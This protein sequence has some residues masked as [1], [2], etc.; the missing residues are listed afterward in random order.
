MLL[1]LKRAAMDVPESTQTI[2][3]Q[4]ERQGIP[5]SALRIFGPEVCQQATQNDAQVF[6]KIRDL[7]IP[8]ALELVGEV[9]IDPSRIK[10]NLIWPEGLEESNNE[11]KRKNHRGFDMW[12]AAQ[13]PKD[14]SQNQ[15]EKPPPLE[16]PPS[17]LDRT[18]QWFV[19]EEG[20]PIVEYTT[21]F[22]IEGPPM[23][24][25]NLGTGFRDGQMF[26]LPIR[27]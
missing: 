4:I 1:S 23:N 16:T 15:E 26:V 22:R 27:I 10:A 11:V 17:D 24:D 19:P 2:I 5:D 18:T 9:L 3:H 8:S 14:E 20:M 7:G 25:R 12:R 21:R 13:F 6:D